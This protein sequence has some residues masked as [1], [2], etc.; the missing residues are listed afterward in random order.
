MQVYLD[1]SATTRQYDEVTDI[2]VKYMKEYYG[3]PSS[4]HAMGFTAEKGLKH[5]R[6]IA[7][8]YFSKM[9]ANDGQVI[10]TS[11]GTESDNLAI[12][13]AVN[14]KKRQGNK[15]ITTEIE[16]PAVLE[17]FKTL[18]KQGFE[19][20]YLPVSED[21]ELDANILK[22]AL[23]SKTILVSVMFVNN[24]V[25]TIQNINEI[26]RLIKEFNREKKAQILLHT[27]AVQGDLR[28]QGIG[29]ADLISISGHKIHGPKGMGALFIKNG[30]R[31]EPQLVGGGQETNLRSGTENLT[32]IVGFS[33]AMEIK[34]NKFND[35][36]ESTNETSSLKQILWR[37]LD[38]NIKDIAINGGSNS[39]EKILSVSFSGVRGEVLLH[40]L[41]QDGIFVSTGSACASNK[42]GQSHVLKAMGKNQKEI[43]SAIRFSFGDFNS[44]DEMDYVIDKVKIAVEKFRKLGSFR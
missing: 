19:A 1:N 24:E 41:E 21:G 25:G 4:L 40:T 22:D 10:F 27:D 14:P 35:T 37:G 6:K 36:K 13:G 9:G 18:E 39:S 20:V 16:H 30:V 42:K 8:E 11:G 23:D 33:K 28:I 34:L 7:T 43:E 29:S 5:A 17:A 26:S 2:M 32:A 31:I 12:F 38:E 44:I 3:N 15:I